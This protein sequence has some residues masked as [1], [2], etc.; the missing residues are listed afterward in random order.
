[1]AEYQKPLPRPEDPVLTRPFWEAARRHQLIIQRCRPCGR[2][3]WSP[4]Q[5]CPFCLGME[6]EW[7]PVSGRA[8]LY[9]YTVVRQSQ[10]PSFAEDVPYAYAI[11]AL[12]EGVRMISNVVGCKVPD[13]LRMEMPLQAVFDDVTPQWTLVKFR[14][15]PA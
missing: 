9:T 3:F 7:T 14:P 10:H 11:V 12:E 4:R 13:D 6:W 5:N 8:R 15:A 1:M 2:F